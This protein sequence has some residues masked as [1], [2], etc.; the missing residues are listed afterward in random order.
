MGSD[1]DSMSPMRPERTRR[2]RRR[3]R[4]IRRRREEER[5]GHTHTHAPHTQY[6]HKSQQRRS[7]SFSSVFGGAQKAPEQEAPEVDGGQGKMS[8]EMEAG[9]G[10]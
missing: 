4:K 2:R 1:S 3:R 6:A 5:E 8:Q 9:T 10:L 7:G